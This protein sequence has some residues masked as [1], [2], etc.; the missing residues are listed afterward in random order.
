MT[1]LFARLITA[2]LIFSAGAV[3]AVAQRTT[4][5]VP[6]SVEINGQVRYANNSAPADK[7]LVRAEFFSG[8]DAGQ[9]LTDQ[10]GKFRISGLT[11]AVYVV[12][13][14]APGY[15]ESRQQVD[16]QTTSREYLQFQLA[17][18]KSPPDKPTD[19][20]RMVDARVPAE[21]QKEF[22]EGRAALLEEKKIEV[23]ISRLEKAVNLYPNFLEARLLLGTA[24]MDVRQFD[25]AERELRQT[26]KINPKTAAAYFGLGEVYRRQQKNDEAENALQEGLKLEPKSHQGHFT[27]GLV[28][29]AKGD[30]AKA[31][32][33]VGQALQ[34]KPDYAEAYLLAGNLFLKAR[35]A[36]SALQ[37]FE[38]YLRLE[39]NGQSAAQTREMVE[40]IRKAMAEKKQ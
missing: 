24:Y 7:V 33:E 36:A 26:L 8:G 6:I 15:V 38:E 5:P 37:M 14:R 18:E 3:I 23:G 4:R 21:A 1:Y 17:P 25:K 40:K 31:G 12:T 11:P 13:V 19:L 2:L 28:Y 27:L 35:N 39:P 20:S 34:L 29:F 9:T 30:I 22:D 32:P 16:L 10:T